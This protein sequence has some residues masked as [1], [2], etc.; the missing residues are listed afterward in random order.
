MSP[1]TTELRHEQ[2]TVGGIFAYR[3]DHDGVTLELI[4]VAAPE[5]R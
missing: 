4:Q 3:Q 5:H 2:V 1:G